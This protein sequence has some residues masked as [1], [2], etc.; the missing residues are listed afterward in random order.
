VDL[1]GEW[2]FATGDDPRRAEPAFDDSEW[3]RVG[4]P[5]LWDDFG[6]ADYDGYGWYRRR[7]TA[8]APAATVPLLM[9]IGGVDDDDWV[10]LNGRLIGQGK[11]CY[12]RRLYRVPAGVV[13]AGKNLIAVRIFD[14]A[15]GGGLAVGPITLGEETL[16]DRIELTSCRIEPPAVGQ[17]EMALALELKNKTA[18]AQVV[19]LNGALTDYLQRPLGD[20]AGQL[21]LPPGA[22]GSHRLS[23]RGGECTDYRLALS[24]S[25]GDDRWETFRYLQAD[26]L[27]G[28]RRTWLLSGQ[29]GFLPADDLRRPPQGT[30]Q[31]I[32]VP[33]AGW[34]GWPGKEHSAWFRRTVPV[35]A[36]V[37]GQRLRLRFEAVAYRCD[38]YLNGQRVG[39]HLGGFEPFWV[40]I[41]A[42]AR[43]GADNEL[44]VGVTDWTAGL[45]PGTPV[46]PDPEQL[47][48]GAML[49]P[50]GTRAQATRGIWQ[51]VY[52]VAHGP[53]AVEESRITTSVSR[54]E[55]AVRLRVRNHG[56]GPRDVALR[57][58][59]MDAGRP[60]FAL[61]ERRVTVPSG[62]TVEVEW[63]RPWADAKL[64]WPHD[65]HL[66]DLRADVRISGAASDLS[67]TRFGF[68]EFRIDGKDYRLNGRILRLRGLVCSPQG[69]S[70]EAI[71][72]YFITGMAQTHFTLVRNHMGPRP[73]YYY[74]IADEVGMGLK[75]ES[76]FYCAASSYALTDDGFWRNMAAHVDGMVRRSWNHP[77]VCVWSAENEILHCGGSATPGA[78][79]RIFDLG[80]RMAALDPTRPIEYEGDGDLR[81]RAATINIHY[82]REFGCHDHNLW[83][84]DAWWLGHEGNDRW[85]QD[86]VWKGDK[87]L[88]MGEFCYFP[89]SRPPGGVS[90]FVGDAAY[91]SRDIERQAHG[92]GVR[93]ICEGARWAGV[94]GLN[95]WVGEAIYGERCLTPIA[96]I[97][98]EWDHSYWAGE[99]VP[100]HLLVLNDTPHEEA[101]ELVVAVMRGETAVDRWSG[102]RTL[103]PGGRWELTVDLRMPQE[104]GR[105]MLVARV[106]RGQEVVYT[107]ERA[108]L[109]AR[110]E[111][112]RAPQG[113]AVAVFDPAGK[114]A[115]RLSAA[116]VSAK[117]L[118]ELTTDS[119]AGIGL[120]IIGQETWAADQTA[121]EACLPAF[122]AAGGKVLVLAQSALPKWLPSGV[123]VDTGRGATM[124][125]PRAPGHPLLEGMDFGGRDLCWWR[126][127]HLV[128]RSLLRKPQ[129]GSFRVI[130]EAG[131]RGGLLWSPLLELPA[132]RGWWLLCQYLVDEK[133]ESEPAARRLLRNALTYAAAYQPP[134]EAHVALLASP[135]FAD[136]LTSL[137]LPA[138]R[139]EA[140]A[141]AQQLGAY[142]LVI[143]EAEALTGEL[144]TFLRAFAEG[145]GT[146][147]LHCPQ[148][149]KEEAIRALT[150]AFER[151]G[152]ANT[153]GHVAKLVHD[154]LASGL[155]NSDLFWYREDC[156]YDDWEGRG[157]GLIDEP[158]AT[159]CVLDKTATVYA[160]PAA[161]A[162][163]AAG[164]GR[165]VVDSLRL[166]EAAPAVADKARRIGAILLTNLGVALGGR[167]S[168]QAYR[169]EPLDL[170]PWLTTALR[171]EVAGDG[172]G[173]WTDQ[174][175]ND[176]RSLP[177]GRQTLGGVS[178]DVADGC[179]AL[180]SATHLTQGPAR[181]EGI[182]VGARC[183]ALFFL[184]A[185]AWATGGGGTIATCRVR[186]QDGQ[187]QEVAMVDGANV[188]DWW[189]PEDLPLAQVAWRG[190]NP[191]HE[192]VGLFCCT[193]RNPRPAVPVATLSL[194]G[195]EAD[196]VYLL[197]AITR[198]ERR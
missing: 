101:L 182:R 34:G 97:I 142:Q 39:E 73:A 151:F 158:C 198:G 26:A 93:F 35:P 7:F 111:P 71:R 62:A 102:S 171:D 144:A 100:R 44:L 53:V 154:G 74:D 136:Y 50:F 172:R 150:P 146:V 118:A 121:G 78:D 156:W 91:E 45:K 59:V 2:R 43:P 174:G 67:D 193:W 147:W 108:L 131:G 120:L 23:F 178:F 56:D 99:R 115:Q 75:D 114:S 98:R 32:T 29:W 10:Y 95:P 166:A 103:A 169:Q 47:P 153:K 22:T 60:V 89:Y 164:R 126:G 85:P 155:S 105:Y 48:D 138:D 137:G 145:G 195:G 116:G 76:A 192:S 184:H 51:D 157:T 31:E 81:G 187:E 140:G 54:G 196:A 186:Y 134:A 65:P 36:Q 13:R 21:R 77:S 88:I 17:A 194:A 161:L 70:R 181:V 87:P 52:L 66:Y 86:L 106:K 6:Y 185:A 132:G 107:E 12:Q 9:D 41:T 148:P 127:D 163:V 122:V 96:A 191:A 168:P 16:G 3:D 24:L 79:A 14:G 123:R 173:G 58:T 117:P 15:M 167:E 92:M 82:P 40:D 176:L 11:G 68:R 189:H 113:L 110:K 19:A 5:A 8:P 135:A 170:R 94:A 125:Y 152:S 84:N 190:A 104:P 112:L 37:G 49:L 20:V 159:Q 30:W 183:D 63:Q 128:A 80:Q 1:A 162:E 179:L 143:V 4:A 139:L 141:T 38:V 57:P 61:D 109:V 119:L 197:V 25:Q 69:A 90:I 33:T 160:R 46:P 27:A 83:P 64:W 124:S 129:T 55:L 165:V 188:G 28:P 130:A 175:E 42:A 180:R 72:D 177:T 149:G 133:L 18:Q